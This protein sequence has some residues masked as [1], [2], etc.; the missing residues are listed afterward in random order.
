M[1]VQQTRLAVLAA[2]QRNVARRD[3]QVPRQQLAQQAAADRIALAHCRTAIGAIALAFI[4]VKQR[5][6]RRHPG[7]GQAHHR[8]HNDRNDTLRQLW[9]TSSQWRQGVLKP[10]F[11]EPAHP[12]NF[13][14]AE[15]SVCPTPGLQPTAATEKS[16]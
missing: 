9:N 11:W 12:D 7:A 10:I 4:I 14:T 5:R 8:Q 2:I 15:C 1:H 13:S 3:P 16:P 6:Q